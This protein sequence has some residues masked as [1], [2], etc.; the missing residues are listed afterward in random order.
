MKKNEVHTKKKKRVKNIEFTLTN[1][2]YIYIYIW[3]MS[4]KIKSMCIYIVAIIT[5]SKYIEECN[6]SR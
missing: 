1:P 2:I 3:R 5:K 4:D 6:V